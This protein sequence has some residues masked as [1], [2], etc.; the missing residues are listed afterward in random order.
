MKSA[1][2]TLTDFTKLQIMDKANIDAPTTTS[3]GKQ[4]E[5]SIVLFLFGIISTIA[6]MNLCHFAP[7][8]MTQNHLNQ[9]VNALSSLHHALKINQTTDVKLTE[10]TPA[11]VS[12]SL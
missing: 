7:K 12:A 11:I 9:E 3:I 2:N 4:V 5:I 6:I 8:V 10:R 1:L